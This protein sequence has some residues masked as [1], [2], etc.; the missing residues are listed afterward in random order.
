MV[1]HL[2]LAR[3][4]SSIE[5]FIVYKKTLKNQDSIYRQHIDGRK[6]YH[7]EPNIN[8]ARGF[9][10]KNAD[11]RTQKMGK[12]CESRAQ[13]KI[14]SSEIVILIRNVV[15]QLARFYS[16][17]IAFNQKHT[18][19]KTPLKNAF[20]KHV[21]PVTKTRLRKQNHAYDTFPATILILCQYT[22]LASHLAE[23]SRGR[24][25]RR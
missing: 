9:Y 23:R 13:S 4:V 10:R 20:D 3:N 14:L 18:S 1:Y 6:A 11:S 24:M 21:D 16:R 22:D 15:V 8:V 12:S 19:L 25:Q 7:I 17:A 2:N 5:M